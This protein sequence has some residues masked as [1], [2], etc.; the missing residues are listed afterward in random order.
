M[1]YQRPWLWLFF[2]FASSIFATDLEKMR[3][4]EKK[5]GVLEKTESQLV[6]STTPTEWVQF[7]QKAFLFGKNGRHGYLAV[8]PVDSYYKW[9]WAYFGDSEYF[10]KHNASARIASFKLLRYEDGRVGI[11]CLN[12]ETSFL[13]VRPVRGKYSYQN[14]IFAT[15]EFLSNN[16]D[17]IA[18]FELIALPNG[19]Y[20]IQNPKGEVSYLAFAYLKKGSFQYAFFAPEEYL[21]YYKYTSAF[22]TSEIT[23]KAH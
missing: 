6:E 1:I 22:N 20:R 4:L 18:K 9:E 10:D 11:R 2:T 16:Q 23:R 7:H 15:E 19:S 8:N 5:V 12:G 17:Y 21:S 14:A 13:A 3:E